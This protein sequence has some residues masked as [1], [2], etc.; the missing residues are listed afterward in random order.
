MYWNKKK[1][2]EIIKNNSNCLLHLNFSIWKKNQHD[3]NLITK[4]KMYKKDN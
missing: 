2:K 3:Q 1:I 4:R